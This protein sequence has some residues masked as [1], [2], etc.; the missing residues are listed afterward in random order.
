[1]P[2]MQLLSNE[3][4]EAYL[5]SKGCIKT[6]RTTD[7]ATGW[8]LPNKVLFLVPKP[9]SYSGMYSDFVFYSIRSFVE[10]NK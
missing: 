7:T 6:D 9:D 5:V 2:A 3:D 10:D 1:M 8:Y 4:V